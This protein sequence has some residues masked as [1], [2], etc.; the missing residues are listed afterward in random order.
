MKRYG[1]FSGLVA[2]LVLVGVARSAPPNALETVKIL[3]LESSDPP[4]AVQFNPKEITIDKSVPWQKHRKSHGDSPTL[5]FTTG[6]PKTMTMELMFDNYENSQN[7]HTTHIQGLE[8]LAAIDPTLNRPP[9]V[10][11]VWGG[12]PSFTGVIENLS[13]R[14][15]LFLEDGT[16]V[17]AICTLRMKQAATVR[18]KKSPEFTATTCSRDEECASQRTCQGGV[19]ALP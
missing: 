12:F 15:T 17:R 11:V 19:C 7:V 10:H 18:A 5:E 6:E 16:P 2:W 13:V 14:Y 8:K 4:Y 3:S 9:M 1:T